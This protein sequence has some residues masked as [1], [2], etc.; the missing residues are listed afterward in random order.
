MHDPLWKERFTVA[1]L[2]AADVQSFYCGDATWDKEAAEWLNG[3]PETI[4][5]CAAN[6]VSQGTEVWLYRNTARELVAFGSLGKTKWRVSHKTGLLPRNRS[7]SLGCNP[8][9][10][11]F[12]ARGRTARR[13]VFDADHG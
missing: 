2:N 4:A 7:H 8:K 9:A 3:R 6:R 10:V 1:H 5:D 11:S 13:T 12:Q